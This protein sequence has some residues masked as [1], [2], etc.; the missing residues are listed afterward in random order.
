M[1]RE[2]GTTAHI[3][4][5]HISHNLEVFKKR[6]SGPIIAVVKANAYGHGLAHVIP[7]LS[8]CDAF[9]VATIEEAKNLRKLDAVKRIVLLEGVFNDVELQ[10]AVE[11]KLDVVIHQDYQIELLRALQG[12]AVIDVWLKVDT[13]MNRLGFSVENVSEKINAIKDLNVVNQIRVMTHFSTANDPE[14][15]QTQAQLAANQWVKSLGFEYSFSNTAAVL[16]QLSE[17]DEWA[18]V[19]LGLYGMSPLAEQWAAD[20]NLRPA[21]HL[22]ANVI[23]TKNIQKGEL[24]GYGGKF[25]APQSMRV[26]IIGMGYGDG[27]PWSR[28]SSQVLFKGK[29]VAVVGRISM[30]MMAIDLTGFEG[31]LTGEV[32]TI[33]GDGL[34]AEQVAKDL[35]LIPYTLTCGVTN[36]VKIDVIQ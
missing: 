15:A 5:A 23:A 36:R 1:N 32:V 34:P 18:R 8:A 24:V 21:M 11:F 3:H 19:G 16:G 33:W 35:E 25:K 4:T 29:L 31:D 6:H 26:G 27:Y 30:D 13:G 22:T 10:A 2:R 9:A 7:A 12:S 14:C 28:L 17:A 20:F